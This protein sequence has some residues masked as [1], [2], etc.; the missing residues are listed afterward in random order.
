MVIL[1]GGSQVLRVSRKI[2]HVHRV[3]REVAL[4]GALVT[5]VIALLALDPHGV[6]LRPSS[7]L[8]DD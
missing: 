8:V 1:R 7:L 6:N 3:T 5:V 4:I 2:N